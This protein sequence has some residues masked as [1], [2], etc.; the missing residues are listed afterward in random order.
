MVRK[1]IAMAVVD[2]ADILAVL[3]T[4][5][6]TL[7]RSVCFYLATLFAAFASACGICDYN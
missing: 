4:L 7:I 6:W 3:S 5:P 2:A 1:T